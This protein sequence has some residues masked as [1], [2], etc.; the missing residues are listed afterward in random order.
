MSV[1][2][3][4]IFFAMIGLLFLPAPALAG[5]QAG[6]DLFLQSI[7][8]SLLPFWVGCKLLDQ[9][10]LVSWASARVEGVTRRLLGCR[11]EA[12]YPL[13]MGLLSGFPTGARL[14][15]QLVS[16]HRLSTAEAQRLLPFCTACS[17][18]F[19]IGTVGAAFWG[20][21]RAGALLLAC[22]YAALLSVAFLF[23]GRT[24]AP[25]SPSRAAAPA[26]VGFGAALGSAMGEAMPILWQVGGFIVLFSAIIH[27]LLAL[28]AAAW[29]PAWVTALLSGLL[30][31]SSGCRAASAGGLTPLSAG[32]VCA[33]LSFSGL[34][35]HAQSAAFLKAAGVPMGRYF[36]AKACQGVVGFGVAYGVF[37]YLMPSLPAAVGAAPQWDITLAGGLLALGIG[38]LLCA[39][40]ARP[41][42]QKQR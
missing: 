6:L 12:A 7:L 42:I 25:T 41:M 11:G 2:A 23:R 37:S 20:D 31:M 4:L 29:L 19:A 32:L 27:T 26:P 16:Q 40:A 18:M 3:L 22:H 21:A 36:A 17:P 28:G 9:L 10:G 1:A 34:C 33:I 14:T 8:P 35:I 15:A 5:A 39:L 30:E 38:A 13:V 24:P